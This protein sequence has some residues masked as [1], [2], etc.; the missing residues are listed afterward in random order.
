MPDTNVLVSGIL[1]DGMPN[2]V[3]AACSRDPI[4]VV[5]S[6]PV[7]EEHRR[8]ECELSKGRAP[9]AGMLDARLAILTVR[10]LL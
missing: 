5:T 9:F 2:H 7:L 8:V 4:R 3:V 6:P 10:A 1:A